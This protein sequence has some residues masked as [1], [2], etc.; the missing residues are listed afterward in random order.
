MAQQTFDFQNTRKAE[1]AMPKPFSVSDLN[2]RVRGCL[3]SQF[4]LIWVQG[5]ISNFKAHSSGHWY[6]SL[7]DSK[8]QVAAVMFR[9]HNSRMKFMPENGTEVLVRGRITVYEP[10]GNYQV[11]CESIEPVGAG[12]LQKQFEQLKTK[13]K[14]E[15]L[16]DASQ[17][18]PLPRLP[19]KIAVVTSPTGAAI[20]DILNVLERRFRGLEVLVVPTIVQGASAAPK[21]CQALGKAL[22]VRDID[23]V[24]IGRG[25]GSMEDLWCFNDEKLARMIA[26]SEVPIISAVGHEIDFTIADFVADFRAPTPSAAA[27][28]VSANAIELSENIGRLEE[29]LHR[30]VTHQ[31]E[32]LWQKVDNLKRLLV[33]PQKSLQQARVRLRELT[34]R[35]RF[36]ID[37]TLR[38]QRAEI[39]NKRLRLKSPADRVEVLR[40]KVES[41]LQR[42]KQSQMQLLTVFKQRLQRQMSVLDAISPLK[43]VDRGYA[44]AEKDNRVVKSVNDVKSGDEMVVRVSDGLITSEVKGTGPLPQSN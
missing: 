39:E 9:G 8:A 34:R 30:S 10:R 40:A 22:K 25:G 11:F 15:G 13:L 24:I 27:E 6:F 37:S 21:I 1:Q 42:N 5:E 4:D 26:S 31:I 3:E 20:R 38:G 28:V 17:K 29:R 43:V 36:A 12:A 32:E 41:L 35:N 23:A 19:K 33:D 7:K 16:F 14:S 44:I 18:K 2:K